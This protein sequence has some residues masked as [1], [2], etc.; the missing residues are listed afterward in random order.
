M[1][2][3]N[4]MW[5]LDGPRHHHPPKCPNLP[6][7]SPHGNGTPDD[8]SPHFLECSACLATVDTNLPWVDFLAFSGKK[9]RRRRSGEQRPG[10]APRCVCYDSWSIPERLSPW[11]ECALSANAVFLWM[12]RAEKCDE[13]WRWDKVSQESG[14]LYWPTAAF[15]VIEHV[16]SYCFL[17]IQKTLRGTNLMDIWIMADLLSPFVHQSMCWLR[18]TIVSCRF[19]KGVQVK[20]L[21]REK[22]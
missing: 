10:S 6:I 19:I 15:N 20:W 4:E 9:R 1:S 18:K 3:C 21:R 14:A 11:G 5:H 16:W 7:T 13:W 17:C 12:A 22:S 2:C 8:N